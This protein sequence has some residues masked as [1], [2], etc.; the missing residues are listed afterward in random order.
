MATASRRPGTSPK[1]VPLA[2]SFS[3]VDRVLAK[4]LFASRVGASS[5]HAAELRPPSN[6]ESTGL[7]GGRTPDDA[8][9]PRVVFCLDGSESE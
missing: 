2:L 4:K 9:D 1:G 5:G 6:N 3:E 7:L 8:A